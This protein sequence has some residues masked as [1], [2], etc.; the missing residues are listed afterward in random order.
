MTDA[1]MTM[2]AI[3]TNRFR[4]S[5]PA[6]ACFRLPFGSGYVVLDKSRGLPGAVVALAD[7]TARILRNRRTVALLSAMDARELA[8]IGLTRADV[9]DAA[10]IGR[11]GHP[12][13]VLDVRAADR[14]AR[15]LA[16]MRIDR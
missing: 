14:A 3:A 6:T 2:T 16:L 13:S 12:L 9:V 11:F 8:D 10:E 5:R 7:R 1:T 4:A 15:D